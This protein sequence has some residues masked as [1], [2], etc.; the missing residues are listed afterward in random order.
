[1]AREFGA[2]STH[3]VVTSNSLN[4]AG[5]LSVC[6]WFQMGSGG[7]Q[8]ARIVSNRSNAD[9]AV[10]YL[11]GPGS[12]A[13][14]D[15]IR[16]L[17]AVGGSFRT[18]KSTTAFDDD[19]WHF[20]SAVY[21]AGAT[22]QTDLYVDN[23][24]TPEATSS[25]T[26]GTYNNASSN[27]TIG[28]NPDGTQDTAWPGVIANISVYDRALTAGERKQCKVKGWVRN[29]VLNMPIIGASTEPDY[30][31]NGYNGTVTGTSLADNPPIGLLFGFDNIMPF[32][33]TV[34][35]AFNPSWARKRS[36]MIGA[37]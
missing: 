14:V 20:F 13:D 32:P 8:N 5:S 19:A 22:D 23:M 30:S 9:G 4:P 28:S 1:M 12:S 15:K 2:G 35:G 26:W 25:G 31:G 27:L 10:G 21:T 37:R 33:I 6:G 16:F 3:R 34:G 11:I 36:F 17:I 7:A 29:N 24:D 18:I